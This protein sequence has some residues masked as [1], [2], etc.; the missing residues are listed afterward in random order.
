MRSEM[1]V[2]KLRLMFFVGSPQRGAVALPLL[3]C[4]GSSLELELGV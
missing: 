4:R 3:C 2:F 1:Y